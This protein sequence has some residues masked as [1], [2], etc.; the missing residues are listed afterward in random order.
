MTK[1]TMLVLIPSPTLT[2]FI[3]MNRNIRN[4]CIMQEW[5]MNRKFI[6]KAILNLWVLKEHCKNNIYHVR[7]SNNSIKRLVEE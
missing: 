2:T 3:I 5:Q 1:G 4:E 7:K 6:R